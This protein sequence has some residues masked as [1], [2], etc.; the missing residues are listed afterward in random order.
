MSFGKGISLDHN[1]APTIPG[2]FRIQD[3]AQIHRDRRQMNVNESILVKKLTDVLTNKDKLLDFQHR[4]V[5]YGLKEKIA[6]FCSF[7]IAY[8]DVS[9]AYDLEEKTMK[10]FSNIV[11]DLQKKLQSMPRN[12]EQ[13]ITIPLDNERALIIKQDVNG[14][15]R[16]GF[17]NPS[18][19]GDAEFFDIPLSS[20]LISNAIVTDVIEH[21]D[22]Y[23]EDALEDIL[24]DR[25]GNPTLN[26]STYET[27]IQ[28]TVGIDSVV[29]G[30]L[31]NNA[32][33]ELAKMAAMTRDIATVK[34]IADALLQDA[35]YV[36]SLFSIDDDQSL[37]VLEQLSAELK[38]DPKYV[39]DSV[40]VSELEKIKAPVH[41]Q[42]KEKEEYVKAVKVHEFFADIIFNNDGDEFDNSFDAKRKSISGSRLYN[43]LL[44]HFDIAF[45]IFNDK[46]NKFL[47]SFPMDL[48]NRTDNLNAN[49]PKEAG[50]DIIKDIKDTIANVI[51]EVRK[52]INDAAKSGITWAKFPTNYKKVY[53][54][55]KSD[56]AKR[57]FRMAVEWLNATKFPLADFMIGQA[58]DAACDKISVFLK[59]GINTLKNDIKTSTDNSNVERDKMR[60]LTLAEMMKD[61]IDPTQGYPRL[62]LDTMASY[63]DVEKKLPE[64]GDDYRKVDRRSMFASLIRN[65]VVTKKE[66]PSEGELIGALF[67][68]AGPVM[69]KALQGLDIPKG[70][71]TSLNDAIKDMKSKLS[72]IPAK[73][74]KAQLLKIVKS[75][76]GKI[77]N[78][79]ISKSLGAASVGLA[80][81][82]KVTL[83][84]GTEKNCV[85]K[86]L[87]PDARNR[88]LR[89]KLL[90]EKVAKEIDAET[91][92]NAI[93]R[94]FQGKFSV[95]NDEFDFTKE[96]KNIGSGIVY[97]QNLTKEFG[98][99]GVES[100]RLFSGVPPTSTAMLLELAPGSDIATLCESTHK[101]RAQTAQKF[102]DYL[103]HDP[104]ESQLPI[105]DSLFKDFELMR[106]ASKRLM[107]L[108]RQWT[109]EA[110]FRTGFFHGDLHAGNIIFETPDDSTYY[111][112]KATNIKKL[113]NKLTVIDFGNAVSL[114]N[115]DK[116][117]ATKVIMS[118]FGSLT[119]RFVPA[120]KGLLTPESREYFEQNDKIYTDA[121]GYLIDADK[122][123]I[124]DKGCRMH[125][126]G[127]ADNG[128]MKVS[129]IDNNGIETEV[130]LPVEKYGRFTALID[131]IINTGNSS[132]VGERCMVVIS[133]LQKN[134]IECPPAIFNFANG[135]LLLQ[136]T[137]KMINN[138]IEAF[139]YP[140]LD[141]IK[142][143][144]KRHLLDNGYGEADVRGMDLE[145][146][147]K[148]VKKCDINIAPEGKEEEKLSERLSS[149]YEMYDKSE[150]DDIN[151]E[152]ANALAQSPRKCV[153][154]L[155]GLGETVG[156]LRELKTSVSQK[157]NVI[158]NA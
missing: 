15:L 43:V 73:Y 80:F 42:G 131:R 26:R 61:A 98:K 140:L 147:I 1:P 132:D 110:L 75:S 121:D 123:Y 145:E 150:L 153:A 109:K 81:L 50:N 29:L 52:Q 70:V 14:Y 82:C 3:A 116:A 34:S 51:Q 91:K 108:V 53:E 124:L 100:M 141:S 85:L 120:Y 37:D 84:D 16:G 58:I 45:E 158:I 40:N 102:R 56:E 94:T 19:P 74:V 54:E 118:C 122:E 97:D 95:I 149:Y 136:N 68:G 17:C 114:S 22:F 104:L 28:T 38:R 31:N 57:S 39:S 133:R 134:G 63:F 67:K 105:A 138:E 157:N 96:A 125:F 130:Q 35:N 49:L 93:L 64:S 41:L 103:R 23:N 20:E 10:D 8:S 99:S 77:S 92:S 4:H 6:H 69:Q 135:Y 76:K 65:V 119:H 148:T 156:F 155:G 106:M 151:L 5:T 47:D 13:S 21:A 83:K 129:K 62:I 72:P 87:R 86:L 146:L 89:D 127:Y 18:F 11:L 128:K 90:F 101:K 154:N 46:D 115:E 107:S 71:D 137:S 152:M 113:D 9:K 25:T 66:K 60:P 55:F 139:N 88:A 27:I 7:G 142:S 12:G 32:M 30:N 126:D 48:L 33:R 36:Q 24:C 79:T 2:A 117:N 44:K 144:A 78:I 112:T 111:T 143:M 59:D